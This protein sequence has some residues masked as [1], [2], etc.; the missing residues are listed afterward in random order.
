[1]FTCTVTKKIIQFQFPPLSFL[2]L[3]QFL[4]AYHCFNPFHN[5]GFSSKWLALQGEIHRQPKAHWRVLRFDASDFK[6]LDWATNGWHWK[7]GGFRTSSVFSPAFFGGV[8]YSTVSFRGF[9]LNGCLFSSC[10]V[11]PFLF[12]MFHWKFKKCGT[13]KQLSTFAT[14]ETY[15]SMILIDPLRSPIAPSFHG[16]YKKTGRCFFRKKK[17][18]APRRLS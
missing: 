12:S 11:F 2:S 4:L 1:M 18:H 17:Y 14:E 16:S 13:K 3:L 5:H 9:F 15:Q 10:V 6:R 7:P 8:R